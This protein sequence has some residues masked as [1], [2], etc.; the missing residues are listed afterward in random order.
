MHMNQEKLCLIAHLAMR[1]RFQKVFQL[2]NFGLKFE[3]QLEDAAQ[4]TEFHQTWMLKFTVVY[5]TE[6][7]IRM[8]IY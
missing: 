3:A 2:N 1:M 6:Y 7:L 8:N 4:F 5:Q